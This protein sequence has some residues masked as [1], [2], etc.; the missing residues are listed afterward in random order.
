VINPKF[1]AKLITEDPDVFNEG[2]EE[3][4]IED[5]NIDAIPTALE[6][7]RNIQSFFNINYP[8]VELGIMPSKKV[9]VQ[10]FLASSEYPFSISIPDDALD[11]MSEQRRSS[12]F[13]EFEK[14]IT[15]SGWKVF[16]NIT[17]NE[18]ELVIA[19]LPPNF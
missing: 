3:L 14:T 8:R 2:W 11:D 13:Q 12:F 4:G 17:H 7:I 1:I 6:L 18:D 10:A 5:P 16:P 15:S 9:N 19:I